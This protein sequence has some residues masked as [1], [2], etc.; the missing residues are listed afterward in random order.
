MRMKSKLLKTFSSRT[1]FFLLLGSG[2]AIGALLTLLV[3]VLVWNVPAFR[4]IGPS[5]DRE[6]SAGSGND[7]IRPMEPFVPRPTS[8]EEMVE[9]EEPEVDLGHGPWKPTPVENPL[10]NAAT[11]LSVRWLPNPSYAT[12]E[13]LVNLLVASDATEAYAHAVINKANYYTAEEQSPRFMWKAGTVT[14]AGRWNGADVYILI[15]EEE[16]IGGTYQTV[17]VLHRK[18]EAGLFLTS[19][20]VDLANNEPYSYI[21]VNPIL[22]YLQ[23]ATAVNI[24]LPP[25]PP[26]T[27]TLTDGARLVRG[28]IF[29]LGFRESFRI[30]VDEALHSIGRTTDDRQVYQRQSDYAERSGD[31]LENNGCLSVFGPDGKEFIYTTETIPVHTDVPRPYGGPIQ[32][33]PEVAW[34]SG[35]ANS[36]AYT[37]IRAGGCG[38]YGCL[39]IS[40]EQEVYSGGTLIVV[41]KTAKGQDVYAPRNP[42]GHPNVQKL[43]DTWYD[44]R[45][46]GEDTKPDINA[47]LETYPVPIFYWKDGLDR[48]VT[49]SVS[50]AIPAGE[51]GK[52]VIYLYPEQTTD[53]RV[54]LPSF[55]N[56]TVSDPAYPAQGWNVTA[57]PDGTLTDHRDGNTYGSLYWEGTG[58]G[59]VPPTEGWVVRDGDVERFLADTLPRYG[60]NET[61]TREFMEFWVPEMT[62]APF[63]RVSFLTSAWNNAAPLSVSPRPDTVI[64]LFMD[65]RPLSAPISLTAPKIQAPAREGFTLVE[66]G[67]T[68]Y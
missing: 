25:E 24:A 12:R 5:A 66:W 23:D 42:A 11:T 29:S 20:Q 26:Q 31:K 60:L 68:L 53:V 39:Y 37:A 2:I 3:A 34:S 62:G 7:R 38:T 59:Y 10:D 35:Y 49:Y 54:K 4:F 67:G 65:W 57:Q 52:P 28:D 43:Y 22:Q 36:D 16:G 50:D 13:E 48:W 45:S 44:W 8:T 41:G 46:T 1:T 17:H 15:L 18:N 14:S 63:Y 19:S 61:E 64:R 51:C 47:F 55:I 27:L 40:T 30:G 56:V 9:D 58:V 21:Y 6:I 33:I 32:E